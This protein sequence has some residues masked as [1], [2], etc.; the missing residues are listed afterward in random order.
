MCLCICGP[1]IFGITLSDAAHLFDI[2]DG[3]LS[4]VIMSNLNKIWVFHPG[5]G[6]GG[7]G[8]GGSTP[9]FYAQHAYI[10]FHF[11]QNRV[12]HLD[13]VPLTVRR[14]KTRGSV[15]NASTRGILA[16]VG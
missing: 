14:H 4:S 3:L 16:D 9:S 7:G 11:F 15:D 13:F 10:Y 5:G 1:Q 2:C 6:G 8:G 12:T